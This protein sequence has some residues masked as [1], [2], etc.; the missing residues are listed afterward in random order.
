M[1]ATPQ[2]V[3]SPL[4]HNLAAMKIG[5]LGTGAVGR[6]LGEKLQSLG[7]EVMLGTRDVAKT[8]MRNAG[9]YYGNQPF[10]EWINEH[11]GIAL[12]TFS[13]AA[14]F[15]ELLINAVNGAA[16]LNVLKKAGKKNMRGK[17]LMDLS[18]PLDFSHGM[19]PKLFLS[20]DNSL[21]E[22]I[23]NAFPEVKVVKTLNTMTASIMINPAA[24]GGEHHVFLCGDDDEARQTVRELL[25]S[26]GWK[27]EWQ[28]DLGDITGA[29]ATE[30]ML[31]VWLRLWAKLQHPAFN[32]RIVV[33]H[34]KTL[35]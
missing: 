16:T 24:L 22:E 32:F 25:K 17:V 23:Q 9:D 6:L 28:I 20:N 1:Q 30:Q 35:D 14:L 11:P 2:A 13:D 33:G 4:H 29:R 7:H 26:L 27:E 12:G 3:T 18:N 5:I 8:L 31:P 19:P 34:P 10:K 15:G 21:G